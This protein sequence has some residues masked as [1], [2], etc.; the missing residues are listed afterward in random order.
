[1]PQDRFSHPGLRLLHY[2][3]VSGEEFVRKWSAL[4]RAGHARYRASRAP[5]ARALKTLV[6]R[7][8][9]EEVREKYLH[10]IYE[11]TTRDDVELLGELGLL[12]EVDPSRGT[13]QPRDLP[14]GG[15]AALAARVAE[16]REQ[17]KRPFYVADAPRSD[18]PPGAARRGV[19]R[20]KRLA[21]RDQESAD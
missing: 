15:P 6:E 19:R 20:L 1:M 3:A 21:A 10:R 18:E 7:D 11:T 8:L 9:P 17:P 2:D 12:V 4:A 5:M 16:L 13:H 14:E